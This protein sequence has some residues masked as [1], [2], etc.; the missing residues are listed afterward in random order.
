MK[1]ASTQLKDH[2]AGEVSTVT[3]CWKITRVDSV[4]LGFTGHTEDL[5]I[6][7]VTYRS[8]QGFTPTNVQTSSGLNVDNLNVKGLLNSLGITDFDVNSG[9]YDGASLEIFLVNYEDLTQ[10]IM[11]L[12]RGFLGNVKMSRVGF[13]AEI[14]GLLERY[15]RQILEVYAPACRADLG[16]D[17]CGVALNPPT[18]AATTAYTDRTSGDAKTGDV[19]KPTTFNGAYFFCSVAGTSGG[20]E[21]SWDTTPGNTTTDGSVTWT[22][23]PAYTVTGSVTGVTSKRVFQDSTR[24]EADNFFLGGLITWTSGVN[25]GLS[26][27]V[28]DYTLST[29]EIELVLPMRNTIQIG[30]TY[31]MYA[32]CDKIWTTCRDK[33]GNIFNFRGEP[34]VPQEQTAAITAIR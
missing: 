6:G 23:I 7:G 13:E 27:E 29:K 25:A 18:W 15:T 1:S 14:R 19:V 12:R 5:E 22:A 8:A 9:L 32:G 21:P 34:Y 10:G 24:A 16:D 3:I 33:F 2:L 31:S 20:S 26:M 28:K 30:D 4:I 17:R 11:R